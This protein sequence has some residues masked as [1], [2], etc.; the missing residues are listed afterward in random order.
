M[1]DWLAILNS[2]L[3]LV[4]V[5]L[6]QTVRLPQHQRAQLVVHHL[7]GAVDVLPAVLNLK[8]KVLFSAE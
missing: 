3:C 1:I 2:Y 8:R 6:A 7:V 4:T 5:L